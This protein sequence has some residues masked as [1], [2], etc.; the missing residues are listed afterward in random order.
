MGDTRV[1]CQAPSAV[2]CPLSCSITTASP[3]TPQLLLITAIGRRT[4]RPRGSKERNGRAAQPG[5]RCHWRVVSGVGRSRDRR[6]G[7]GLIVLIIRTIVGAMSAIA[8]GDYLLQTFEVFP[9]ATCLM[10]RRELSISS[11]KM[12]G[13]VALNRQSSISPRLH[14]T[15]GGHLEFEFRNHRRY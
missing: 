7:F 5:N 8:K 9:G 6:L 14:D 15:P 3:S 2:P 10:R 13:R 12:H 1:R 4:V 11:D